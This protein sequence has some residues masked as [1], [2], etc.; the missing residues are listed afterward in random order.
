MLKKFRI[1]I[2]F[3]VLFFL[4]ISGGITGW[5]AFDVLSPSV[6]V[7]L[8]PI[9]WWNKI[10]GG[11]KQT[12][13]ITKEL[14]FENKSTGG[15]LEPSVIESPELSDHKQFTSFPDKESTGFDTVRI[16]SNGIIVAGRAPALSKVEILLNKKVLSI[17]KTNK[18]G[19]FSYLGDSSVTSLFQNNSQNIIYLRVTPEKGKAYMSESYYVVL[20]NTIEDTRYTRNGTTVIAVEGMRSRVM[21][22]DKNGRYSKFSIDIVDYDS[23]GYLYLGGVYK[24]TSYGVIAVYI[25]NKLVANQRSDV[26]SQV[27]VWEVHTYTDIP[28]GSVLVR[29]DLIVGARVISRRR[30]KFTRTKDVLLSPDTTKVVIRRGDT[31]WRIAKYVYGSGSRYIWIF[32]NNKNQIANPEVIYPRQIFKLP[33]TMEASS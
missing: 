14:Q 12:I 17:V 27:N 4:L 33:K 31:L 20:K 30:I 11:N 7:K 5:Y 9:Y 1:Q 26:A 18:Y 6:A 32:T 19:S 3:G 13:Y 2:L 22:A 23:R 28:P 24:K 29:V 15:S 21:Q 25:N 16:D 8:N 10:T